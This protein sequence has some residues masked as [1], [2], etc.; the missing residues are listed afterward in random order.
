MRLIRS[1]CEILGRL[2][3]KSRRA[4]M[5]MQMARGRQKVDIVAAPTRNMSIG[6]VLSLEGNSPGNPPTLSE[7]KNDREVCRRILRDLRER[8]L[9]A[10]SAVRSA[11]GRKAP[12]SQSRGGNTLR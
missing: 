5:D 1:A 6:A 3:R 2:L 7:L 12:T 8:S 4:V 11:P 9:A 10:S